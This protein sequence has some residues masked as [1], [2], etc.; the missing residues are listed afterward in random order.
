MEGATLLMGQIIKQP[1]GRYAIWSSVTDDFD[2]TDMT[3]EE[4]VETWLAD[5][6]E[7]LTASVSKIITALE[8]GERPY[9]QFTMTWNEALRRRDEVRLIADLD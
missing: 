5:Q 7:R 2:L 8:N 1:D 4:I 9:C 3:P 6:R